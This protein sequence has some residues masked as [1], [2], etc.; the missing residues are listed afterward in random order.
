[1]DSLQLSTIC[2][3]LL[4]TDFE[5]V[6]ASNNLPTG[7]N[8]NRSFIINTDSKNLP[9]QHWI[10]VIIRDNVGYVFDSLSMIPPPL[11]LTNWMNQRYHQW[12][13]NKRRVQP[14][15]STLC[16]VYCIHFLYY[17]LNSNELFDV[18]FD[19][20]YPANESMYV[21]EAHIEN[22]VN[23]ILYNVY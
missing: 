16:G 4:G 15:D 6:F 8:P 14:I 5:G 7:N 9:G 19:S 11:R 17:V 21:H 2:N 22:F 1:M 13:Y 20:L 3:Q 18:V 12:N 10:A 23:T